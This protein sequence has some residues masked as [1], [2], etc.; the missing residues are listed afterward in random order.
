MRYPL[1]FSLALGALSAATLAPPASA[2]IFFEGLEPFTTRH[3]DPSDPT[4]TD[5]KVLAPVPADDKGSPGAHSIEGKLPFAAPPC[6][7]PGKF[8]G[9]RK[10]WQSK[11]SDREPPQK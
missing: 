6:A 8:S 3:C 7:A 5:P 9:E 2:G 11:P 1:F 4:L 10:I